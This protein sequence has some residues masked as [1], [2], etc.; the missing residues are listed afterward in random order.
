MSNIGPHWHLSHDDK[1][2]DMQD[3]F[4][5]FFVFF[6]VFQKSYFAANKELKLEFNCQWCSDVLNRTHTEVN[7]EP[8]NF[9]LVIGA[10][11]CDQ[12][13]PVANSV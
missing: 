10:K 11:L 1:S 2:R 7:F 3:Y 12:L 13:E 4:Y 5:T 6:E 9:L 8:G